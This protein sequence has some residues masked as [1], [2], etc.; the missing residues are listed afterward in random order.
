MRGML[1]RFQ[2]LAAIAAI[3][4]GCSGVKFNT[5]NGSGGAGSVSSAPSTSGGGAASGSVTQPGSSGSSGS[6]TQPGG[7]TG[8][9]GASGTV[10]GAGNA[11]PGNMPVNELPKVQFIGPPCQRLSECA[12][13]FQL[14]KAYPSQTEF[15]WKTND[16]LYGSPPQ[17]GLPP[18]G[19]PG[20]PGD[21]T[22]QYVPTSGHAVFPAG[23]TSIT[24]YVQNINQQDTAISIGV[25]M[26]NCMYASLSYSCQSFFSP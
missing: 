17:A 8:S 6:V 21:I 15:D 22:A 25:L 1:I 13:T 11:P 24:V 3:A 26:S 5:S 10:V 9:G 14:D 18:W 16:T 20:Q 4:S 7:T 19:K 23:V 2:V 12:V